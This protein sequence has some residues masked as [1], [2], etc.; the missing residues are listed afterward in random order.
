[1]LFMNETY[2]I[3]QNSKYITIVKTSNCV[4]K[5]NRSVVVESL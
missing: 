4:I 3:C 5:V 2:Q 1:M